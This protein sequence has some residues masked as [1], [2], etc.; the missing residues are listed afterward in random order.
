LHRVDCLSSHRDL[1]LYEFTRE[2]LAHTPPQEIRPSP[3]ITGDDL[4]AAGYQPGPQ[5]K[6]ILSALE[7]LQLE[8]KLHAAD[9]AMAWVRREFPQN[10]N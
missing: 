7:D 2:K 5:F 4:I 1:S 9:E 6:Q 10:K 3:L 8:G